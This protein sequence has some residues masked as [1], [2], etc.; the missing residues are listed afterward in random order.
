MGGAGSGNP[1]GGPGRK[2]L[3]NERMTL[4][5]PADLVR[6]VRS[7]AKRWGLSLSETVTRLMRKSL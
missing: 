7:L 4:H 3:G 2:P 6:R 5:L 1:Q